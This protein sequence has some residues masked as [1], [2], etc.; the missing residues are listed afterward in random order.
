MLI[1]TVQCDFPMLL[2]GEPNLEDGRWVACSTAK[3][4][5]KLQAC[6]FKDFKVNNFISTCSTSVT[7]NL[8]T[9]RHHDLVNHPH[10]AEKYLNIS[11]LPS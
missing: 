7:G 8:T 5:I 10:M 6:C 4:K 2:L 1:K 3:D 9:T 11:M